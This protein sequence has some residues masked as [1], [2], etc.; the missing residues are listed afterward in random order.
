MTT[1]E[2]ERWCLAI[3]DLNDADLL[4]V[5]FIAMRVMRRR[6]L[7]DRETGARYPLTLDE[8]LRPEE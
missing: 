3:I 5:M 7:V 2:Y 6:E 1:E 4:K 8:V